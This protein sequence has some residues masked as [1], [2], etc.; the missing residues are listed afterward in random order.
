MDKKCFAYD[1]SDK[2]CRALHNSSDCGLA[3]P[4]RKSRTRIYASRRNAYRRLAGLPEE[5]QQHI[6]ETYYGGA[7]PWRGKAR[8]AVSGI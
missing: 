8:K 2:S 3:C 5:Q 7:R 1:Q 4:F 6:A